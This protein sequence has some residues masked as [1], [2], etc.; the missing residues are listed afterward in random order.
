MSKTATIK[1]VALAAGVSIASVS[2]VVNGNEKVA[3][4]T[5]ER[6]LQAMQSLNYVPHIG[7]RSLITKR[8]QNIGVLLPDLY[9]EFF[10]EII[11]GID[12]AAREKKFHLLV[13]NARDGADEVAAAI[14]AMHGRVDGLLVMSPQVNGA[15]LERNLSRDLP[16]V[17]MNTPIGGQDYA[18]Y[19]ID[20]YAG[21]RAMVQHLA[22]QGYKNIAF[23]SGPKNNHDAEERLRGFQDAMKDFLP[24]GQAEIIEGDFSEESGAKAGA[25]LAQR[26][27]LPDAVFAA[28]DMMAVGCLGV[29][30]DAGISI[31]R[32]IALAGF[33]DIPIARYVAPALTTMRVH[34]AE[35]GRAAFERLADKIS[36]ADNAPVTTNTLKP[37]LVTRASTAP[38]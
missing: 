29:L 27:N 13:A 14:R 37:E 23:I 34:I 11:R 8:T 10:S 38:T 6:V 30:T 16:T 31:P 28:N 35:L 3:A 33:D 12:T 36:G 22:D 32:D 19:T 18:A 7:A 9:G 15:L 24:Q 5:K 4:E 21:A 26:V 1:D 20:N 2:R 17:L 25:L